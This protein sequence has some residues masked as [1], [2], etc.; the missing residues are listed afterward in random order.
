MTS[1]MLLSPNNE[2][3]Y[4]KVIS[5]DMNEFSRDLKL[6]CILDGFLIWAPTDLL[7]RTSEVGAKSWEALWLVTRSGEVIDYLNLFVFG[8]TYREISKARDCFL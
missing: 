2:V 4:A 5:S 6:M 1:W 3:A 7:L 8:T